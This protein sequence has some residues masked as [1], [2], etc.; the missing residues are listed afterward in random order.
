[1]S[2]C[3]PLTEAQYQQVLAAGFA[4]QYALRDRALFVTGVCTGYRITELLA[5]DLGAI[6][7]PDANGIVHVKVDRADMKGKLTSRRTALPP[8]AVSAI[9]A[10]IACLGTDLPPDLPLFM[11]QRAGSNGG[12]MTENAGWRVLKA[13]FARAGVPFTGTHVMRKTFARRVHEQADKD[14]LKTRL[15]LKHRNLQSTVSYLSF[16]TEEEIDQ[17]VLAAAIGQEKSGD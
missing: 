9:S 15:A 16:E 17:L 4:G 5:I 10:W 6:E 2:G 8:E 1:M 11:S 14:L 12:R 3:I 13:A 7:A